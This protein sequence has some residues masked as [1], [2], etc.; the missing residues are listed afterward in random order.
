MA[1]RRPRRPSWLNAEFINDLES[2][3]EKLYGPRNKQI[4]DLRALRFKQHDFEVPRAYSRQTKKI[5]TYLAGKW[6]EQEVGA[7]ASR[8]FEVSSPP[9]P[10]ATQDD[11]HKAEGRG[12]FLQALWRKHEADAQ[13]DLFRRFVDAQVADGEG[14]YRGVYKPK[15]WEGMPTLQSHFVTEGFDRDMPDAEIAAKLN[16]RQLGEYSRAFQRFV[17]GRPLPFAV[18][19]VDRMSYMPVR[20]E[21]G[22]DSVLEVSKVPLDVA[23]RAAGPLGGLPHSGDDTSWGA[24]VKLS[25]YTDDEWC[26]LNADGRWVGA[27]QHGH[28]RV[29]YWAAF[30]QE[31]GSSDPRFE[32]ISTLFKLMDVIPI[33]DQLLTMKYR[34][35]FATSYPMWFWK[36]YTGLG[37]GPGGAAGPAGPG[38][39]PQRPSIELEPGTVYPGRPGEEVPIQF[40]GVD[41]G[42]DIEQTIQMLLALSA[43][44][45]IDPGAGGGGSHM[46]GFLQ[47][48]LTELAKTGYHQI[49][50][51]ASRALEGYFSWVLEMQERVLKKPLMLPPTE[52]NR[53]WLTLEPDH[54][55]QY[56]TVVEITPTNPLL[57]MAR[58]QHFTNEWKQGA[59]SWLEATRKK[60]YKNPEQ[61]WEEMLAEKISQMPSMQMGIIRRAVAQL[62]LPDPVVDEVVSAIG[63]AA[64]VG[65]GVT[66]GRPEGQATVEGAGMPLAGPS[67]QPG[68]AQATVSPNGTP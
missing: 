50:D 59:I 5:K 48:Q 43:E 26:A 27:M 64:G 44:T 46:S 12:V 61:M 45:Q 60:G 25:L 30:G 36:G 7:L 10:S 38:G 57:D 53:S 68:P 67:N 29:P 17:A 2:G 9:P 18:R 20:G 66:G 15:A 52:Q 58:G 62:G 3:Q 47:T 28:L 49:P 51:H 40:G 41:I 19:N 21:F 32:G 31:T 33:I 22:I 6:V 56:Q 34:R 16:G 65:Q 13:R 42:Q 24:T 11:R 63:G 1:E 23:R 37:Q 55:G 4:Q 54:D 14:V 39:S 35:S 8:L